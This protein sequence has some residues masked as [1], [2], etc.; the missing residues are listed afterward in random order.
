MGFRDFFQVAC[1][2]RQSV[3]A[4]IRAVWPEAATRSACVGSAGI[5]TTAGSGIPECAVMG[6][7]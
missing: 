5:R 1:V 2:G 3:V 6:E 4:H 7:I